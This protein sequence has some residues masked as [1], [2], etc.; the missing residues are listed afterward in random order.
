VPALLDAGFA[1]ADAE[2]AEL[3][4][5]SQAA[6]ELGRSIV[7]IDGTDLRD[8]RLADLLAGQGRYAELAA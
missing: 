6:L 1:R 2:A 4:S 7:R 8:M 3:G 5:F